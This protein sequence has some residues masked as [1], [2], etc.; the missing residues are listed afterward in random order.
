MLTKIVFHNPCCQTA[1][2]SA[3][4]LSQNSGGNVYPNVT[5]SYVAEKSGS[6]GPG[7][8]ER[9]ALLFTGGKILNIYFNAGKTNTDCIF[10]AVHFNRSRIGIRSC[11]WNF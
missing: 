9:F 10:G 6:N 8:S 2:N 3:L 1:E 7:N 4:K 11:I 5:Y